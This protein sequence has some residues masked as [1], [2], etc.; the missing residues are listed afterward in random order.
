M[1]IESKRAHLPD[2]VRFAWKRH[3]FLTGIFFAAGSLLFVTSLA[4]FP[5]ADASHGVPIQFFIAGAMI[6]Q[7]VVSTFL[8]LVLKALGA[9]SNRLLLAAHLVSLIGYAPLAI[10][11]VG[12][13]T[14][15]L[16]MHQNQNA[17]CSDVDLRSWRI[18][19][20][21][22][23]SRY[24]LKVSLVSTS[25]GTLRLDY[26]IL[27][28]SRGHLAGWGCSGTQDCG[29]DDA[30]QLRP[31]LVSTLAAGF[32][33]TAGPASG[34]QFALC[35]SRDTSFCAWYVYGARTVAKPSCGAALPPPESGWP[36]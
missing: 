7:P 16:R 22:R 2:D 5:P 10:G 19:R 13:M 36:L 3:W 33:S 24:D 31:G 18:E 12:D 28:G 29:S 21:D 25:G 14:F 34:I 32:K 1:G 20:T 23:P 15:R 6:L 27:Y 11:F 9:D 26:V 4:V 8:A 30:F 35:R 17:I